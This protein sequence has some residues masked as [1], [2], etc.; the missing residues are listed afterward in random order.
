MWL[1]RCDLDVEIHGIELDL[2]FGLMQPSGHVDFYPNGGIQQPGCEDNVFES[3]RKEQGNLL[4]GM[5]IQA[6]I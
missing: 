1:F 3:I 2:G 4:Y 5:K 6:Q